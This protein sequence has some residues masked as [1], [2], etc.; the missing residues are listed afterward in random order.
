MAFAKSIPVL[1]AEDVHQMLKVLVW[2]QTTIWLLACFN[3]SNTGIKVLQKNDSLVRKIQ[4]IFA[5]ELLLKL[6]LIPCVRVDS[7]GSCGSCGLYASCDSWGSCDSCGSFRV[8]MNIDNPDAVE[9]L[10]AALAR[11]ILIVLVL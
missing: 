6:C 8:S 5:E 2:R 10:L 11:S 9:K 7:C 1:Y 4:G 3:Y